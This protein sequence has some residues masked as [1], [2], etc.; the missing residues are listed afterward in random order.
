MPGIDTR[1]PAKST[2][3][4]AAGAQLVERMDRAPGADVV[5][6]TIRAQGP[7]VG[8]LRGMK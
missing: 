1:R 7:D 8:R 3:A 5:T 6:V 2:A 4:R